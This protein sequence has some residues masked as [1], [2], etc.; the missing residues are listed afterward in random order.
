MSPRASAWTESATS[1]K[2]RDCQPSPARLVPTELNRMAGRS[3]YAA[4]AAR[5]R[6]AT[7]RSDDALRRDFAG[8]LTSDL[9]A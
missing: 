3:P 9:L 7:V 5:G 6:S 8:A 1:V 2:E 4:A